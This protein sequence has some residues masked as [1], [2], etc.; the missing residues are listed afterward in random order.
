MNMVRSDAGSVEVFGKNFQENELSLKQDVA[1]MLGA[2]DYYSRRSL[3]T[4]TDIFKR[5][6]S[7]WDDTV[8]ESLLKRFDIDP[9]KKVKELSHGMKI[10]YSLTLAL[11]HKARLIIL[12]EP[13]SGLDPVARDDLLELF[14]E[15][16]ED[17][18]KS[19]LYSTHITSDLEQC[20]DFITYI[21]KGRIIESTTKDELLDK[22]RLISGSKE[23]LQELKHD[24]ISWKN[25]SFG[26]RGLIETGKIPEDGAAAVSQPKLDDIMIYH[27]KKGKK[28][29]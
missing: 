4:I 18:R 27:A 20:A 13:T 23:Q 28:N 2:C 22:Y 17:G 21:D 1:L 14:Q 3:G 11:S 26:F 16:V 5:F 10:K 7:N 25:H 29:D 19:I 9:R 12:D 8:Y 15:M 6:Y 24:L